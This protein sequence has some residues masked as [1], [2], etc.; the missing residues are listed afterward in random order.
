MLKR[1]EE[2]RLSRH[3]WPSR[4]GV[5]LADE[6]GEVQIK[7]KYKAPICTWMWRAALS[8]RAVLNVEGRP[9]A[10]RGVDRRRRCRSRVSE[11]TMSA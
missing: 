8:A 10:A 9:Q 1:W 4:A 7:C 11:L 2:T 3:P 6:R 5:Y